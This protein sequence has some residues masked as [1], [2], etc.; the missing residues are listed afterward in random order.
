VIAFV[1]TF[2]LM[3]YFQKMKNLSPLEKIS[4]NFFKQLERINN[5]NSCSNSKYLLCKTNL[6]CGFACQIH[7]L[8]LCVKASISLKRVLLVDSRMW[9][10]FD[11]LN[12]E[13]HCKKE[14][15]KNGLKV[16]SFWNCF[17]LP[18]SKCTLEDIEI[19]NAKELR[20]N[21]GIQ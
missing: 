12:D 13:N 6:S 1:F 15:D 8:T 20:N 18:I 4:K 3:F 17:L 11:N 9:I 10:Y 2:S 14:I 21:D 7:F 19:Q 5:P 16:D